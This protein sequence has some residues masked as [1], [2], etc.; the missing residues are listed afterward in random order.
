MAHVK[1]IAP[2]CAHHMRVYI[3]IQCEY[4]RQGVKY[5]SHNNYKVSKIM[6]ILFLLASF[7]RRILLRMCFG[8]Q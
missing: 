4:Y 2:M 5:I 1:F 8:L 7:F 3:E 6:E